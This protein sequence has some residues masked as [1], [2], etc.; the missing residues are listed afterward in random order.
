SFRLEYSRS[1][2][3]EVARHACPPRARCARV[4][5]RSRREEPGGTTTPPWDPS[6]SA[7]A[8]RRAC[9]PL[10]ASCRRGAHARAAAHQ[11]PSRWPSR[12]RT[13]SRSS[14]R[15][16]SATSWRPSSCASASPSRGASRE[17]KR[18]L[19]AGAG[20]DQA[21]AA[22][23]GRCEEGPSQP[24]RLEGPRGAACPS[25]SPREGEHCSRGEFA[26]RLH[27]ELVDFRLSAQKG[28]GPA[29]S[30]ADAFYRHLEGPRESPWQQPAA[31][32]DG[33]PSTAAV[34]RGDW[35]PA[36]RARGGGAEPGEDDLLRRGPGPAGVA[37]RG[38]G[39]VR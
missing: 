23:D 9:R 35:A 30:T 25:G 21:V 31:G 6:A 11:G 36:R 37:G 12:L 10:G 4:R 17:L 18:L 27:Q 22:L 19:G 28:G 8:R 13:R 39:D 7:P 33:E 20:A 29:S 5:V 24:L 38:E 3:A 32:D 16:A 2:R 26:Q 34:T 1:E 15:T 14:R